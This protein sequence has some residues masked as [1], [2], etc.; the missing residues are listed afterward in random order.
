MHTAWFAVNYK[1]Y[2]KI[3]KK[4]PSIKGVLLNVYRD[5]VLKVRYVL[6]VLGV[7][8]ELNFL[9]M[10]T[11]RDLMGTADAPTETHKTTLVKQVM[12][13]YA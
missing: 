2:N 7:S 6:G 3:R 1:A 4:I 9:H 8:K 13:G 10:V 11:A 12:K 5:F